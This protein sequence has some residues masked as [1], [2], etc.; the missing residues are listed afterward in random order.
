[1]CMTV[2]KL[3]AVLS[4]LFTVYFRLRDLLVVAVVVIVIV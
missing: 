4:D 2:S 1:M 3:C